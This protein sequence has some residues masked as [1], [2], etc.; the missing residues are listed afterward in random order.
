MN[1]VNGLIV[2][3]FLS[4]VMVVDDATLF[5]HP[6]QKQDLHFVI[7]RCPTLERLE[8]SRVSHC[9]D[10]H[11]FGFRFDENRHPVV[12]SLVVVHS[13]ELFGPSLVLRKEPFLLDDQA[14]KTRQSLF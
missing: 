6:C 11:G 4:L 7:R 3:Q 8:E 14:M 13:P 5:L 1:G 12:T 9:W 10:D 2:G